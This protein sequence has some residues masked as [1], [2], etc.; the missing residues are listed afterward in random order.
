M[1]RILKAR[2]ERAQTIPT[3][4]A[5]KKTYETRDLVLALFALCHSR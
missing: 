3:K 1:I 5:P 2:L 4:R